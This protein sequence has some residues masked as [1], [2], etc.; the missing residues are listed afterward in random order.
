MLKDAFLC[1][2]H[3]PFLGKQ[4]PCRCIVKET[5]KTSV[6]TED[7]QALNVKMSAR[8]EGVSAVREILCQNGN[9]LLKR[10]ASIIL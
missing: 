6:K 1:K 4:R 3:L 7:L 8:K 5:R 2:Q 10:K 9:C